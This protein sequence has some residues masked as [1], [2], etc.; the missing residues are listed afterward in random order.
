MC[1]FNWKAGDFKGNA[2]LPSS[3]FN[4]TETQTLW[5][6][7]CEPLVCRT[8]LSRGNFSLWS[9]QQSGF[10]Q[11]PEWLR[12]LRDTLAML[13]IVV[14]VIEVREIISN[15]FSFFYEKILSVKKSTERKTSDFY[16][17]RS[18]C[19]KSCCLCCFFVGLF[20]FY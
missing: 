4:G 9:K 15:L 11:N 13:I 7:N 19:A 6:G 5:I 12:I 18:L 16:P 20:L 1:L 14:H 8:F 2:Q 17:L 10:S 3:N